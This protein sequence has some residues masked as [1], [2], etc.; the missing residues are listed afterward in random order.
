MTARRENK[1]GGGSG[2]WWQGMLCGGVATLATPTAVLAGLLLAPAALAWL[3]DGEPDKAAARPVLLCGLAASAG[4]LAA[5]WSGGH[6]MNLA[7]SQAG[8]LSTLGVAWGAQAAGWLAGEVV[9]FVMGLVAEARA[10]SRAAWLRGQRQLLEEEWG[11][12]PAPR[13]GAGAS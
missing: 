11:L 9:P 7:L 10:R 5:L 8:D 6:T 4:P 2:L 13:T 12:P 1:R 3:S